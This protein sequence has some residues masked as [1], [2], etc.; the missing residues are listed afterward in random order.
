MSLLISAFVCWLII[1]FFTKNFDTK[2]L[3]AFVVWSVIGYQ[4][5]KRDKKTIIKRSGAIVGDSEN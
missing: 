3:F 1:S 5:G 4:A 2:I